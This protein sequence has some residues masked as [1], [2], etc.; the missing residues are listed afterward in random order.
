MWISH[1]PVNLDE[2]LMKATSH[3]TF[4]MSAKFLVNIILFALPLDFVCKKAQ[5]LWLVQDIQML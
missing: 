5:T 1:I 3:Y 4:Q 2:V